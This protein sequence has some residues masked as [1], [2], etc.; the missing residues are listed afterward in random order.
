MKNM[1]TAVIAGAVAVIA[2]IAA[3]I[4]IVSGNA[5]N[6]LYITEVSGDVSVSNSDKGTSK[7]AE[8]GTKLSQ[9]DA[10][11]V[12][13][14]GY[15]T[16]IYRTGK[17]KD[18]NYMTV[19]SESQLFVTDKFNGRKDADIYLNRGTV[20]S[21]NSEDL[22]ACANIRT[23][24]AAVGTSCAV[25]SVS[26]VIGEE[27]NYTEVASL[28]GN[29]YI[30]LYDEQGS[31]VNDPEPLG[32][33]R[34]GRVAS[35]KSGP[36]FAYL[37][38]TL[39]LPDF[40]AEQ[41]RELFKMSS[42]VKLEFT[43]EQIK[44]A[45]D[46]IPKEN[47]PVNE[48]EDLD[49]VTTSSISEAAT[50]QTAD[51]I[52]TDEE[53]SETSETTTIITSETT[54]STTT[55]TSQTTTESQTEPTETESDEETSE[56]ETDDTYDEETDDSD[57][58]SDNEDNDLDPDDDFDAEIYTVYIVIN[59]VTS[60]QEVLAGGSAIQPA[61]PVVEGK[62]FIGWDG[63]FTNINSDTTITAIF[64][65]DSSSQPS[66]GEGEHTV[67]II[68]GSNTSTQTVK[69]GGTAS[70]PSSVSVDGYSFKGWDRDA[71][72]ITSDVTITAILEPVS[73]NVTFMVDGI[74]Y[75]T[76][77]SYGGTAAAPVTPGT[78]SKGEAFT[79]WDRS[80]SNITGDTVITAVFESSSAQVTY[81]VTFVADGMSYTQT[82]A[83][84]SA[85]VAPAVPQVNSEGKNFLGWDKDYSDI[86]SDTTVTAVYG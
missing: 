82:V 5:K 75:F 56:E 57:W 61:D 72:N 79:G 71:S 76:T 14:G 70:L 86:E 2:V 59:G 44:A 3:I 30:Q 33:A 51:T 81:T 19:L 60:E 35:G 18:K 32:P 68:I 1:K 15:C 22:G 46:A 50:I 40:S 26:Y 80:L 55:T 41:L 43:S 17:N 77:V 54:V 12:S 31:P 7:K 47:K 49:S 63:S 48:P 34:K 65:D 53:G 37:N 27:V 66:T 20:L 36:Y 11:T 84:G 10:V 4:I 52:A 16:L 8:S 64:E 28:G 38:E 69:D 23:A 73:C 67:T 45:Y 21:S 74:K 39:E 24:N 58:E 42:Y 25:S 78:N 62:K 6:G 29:L 9:G 83:A 13:E 85:A